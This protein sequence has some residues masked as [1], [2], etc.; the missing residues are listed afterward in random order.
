MTGVGKF[1][2][3]LSTGDVY[4]EWQVSGKSTS[5]NDTARV[6]EGL[7]GSVKYFEVQDKQFSSHLPIVTTYVSEEDEVRGKEMALLTRRR[8][9]SDIAGRYRDELDRIVK[10]LDR[11]ID[12]TGRD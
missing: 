6:S 3:C 5:I 12:G 9:R 7:I 1:W 2:N 8:W 4:I 10:G 11:E